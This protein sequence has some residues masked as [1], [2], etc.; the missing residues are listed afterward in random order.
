MEIGMEVMKSN[1]PGSLSDEFLNDPQLYCNR[2]LSLLAFQDHVLEEARDP[3]N[4]LLER[5]K[6]LAIFGSNMDEFFM[7]RVAALRQQLADGGTG[8][9]LDG[10]S[11]ANQLQ[12]IG[13]KAARLT[14]QA[15]ECWQNDILPTLEGEGVHIAD[16]GALTESDRAPLD[17][18]F[19][20]AVLPILTPLGYDPGRPFP[21]ISNLSLNLAVVLQDRAG[22]ERFARVKIPDTIEQLIPVPGERSGV[23][24]F[25]WLEQLILANLEALFPG[26]RIMDAYPFRVTRDAEV[27]IQELESDDLL[28]TI[29]EAVWQRRFRH[30]VRLEITRELPP[31]VLSILTTELD[32]SPDQAY[33]VRGPLG[34]N[35]LL[36]L[37]GVDLPLLKYKRFVP[38]LP[39]DLRPNAKE[40]LFALIRREDVLLHHPFES[41]QPVVD[42]LHAAAVDPQV[43]AIKMTL[44][45]VGKNS[46]IVD[47]L[48]TAVQEGKQVSVLVELKAR[49]DEESNIEWT[50][51]LEREGIHVIYGLVGLKVHAKIALV[52]RREGAVLRKYVHL[53]TGNYN[54]VTARLYTDLSFLTCEERIGNDAVTLFNRLTGYSEDARY[55]ELLVAPDGV[56]TELV[57]R[58]EREIAHAKR[59]ERGQLIAKMNALEDPDMIRWLYRASAAGVQIDLVVRGI[60]CL[61][62]GIPGVSEHIRV[63]SIL[64]RFLEHSRMYYFWNGGQEEML[65]GSADWMTRNLS[66]RV[67]VLFPI[68]NRRLVTRLREVLEIY[69]TDNVSAREMQSDGSY[70]R[71]R[72]PDAAQ[73]VEAQAVLASSVA[74]PLT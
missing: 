16:Y 24:R 43:L 47:S 48:L 46:P 42:F 51:A 44:Y 66:R 4:P 63:R 72:P 68:Q 59:G 41:F 9:S 3:A 54:P 37:A 36:Q 50:R 62:P 22:V 57:R 38:Y 21:H 2:D 30:V 64:G 23:V 14:E 11:T 67:E 31:S 26:T 35:R 56:R 28:E 45:R 53:G 5:V 58:I 73:A 70:V 12:A 34:L 25:V 39:L 60:C 32:T 10:G 33:R 8:P 55:A 18:F 7:V 6:F 61:R 52:V 1:E 65:V 20:D 13:R 15:Y 19:R 69:L 74:Q 17:H 71:L 29:E 49:F 27:E 40:D